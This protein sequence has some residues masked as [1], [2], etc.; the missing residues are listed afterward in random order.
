MI[1]NLKNAGVDSVKV[2]PCIVSNDQRKSAQYH[3][4]SRRVVEEGVNRA[5][6]D[7]TGEGFQIFN[8][9]TGQLATFEKSYTWC[10]SIQIKPVIGADLNL[11]AC[12]DKAYNLAEGLIASI[13]HKRLRD[14]WFLEKESF[15]RINPMRQCRHHCVVND[16]N[17]M[18]IDYLD[19]D[20]EHQVF[21]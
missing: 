9:F 21:V 14:V 10:P 5:L 7:F 6:S 11:Y 8:A 12:Q 18:I 1:G 17:R 20:K 13:R 4:A 16:T 19:V 15:F 3:D 2:S